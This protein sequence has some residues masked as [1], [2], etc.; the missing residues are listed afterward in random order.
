[1]TGRNSQVGIAVFVFIFVAPFFACL[2]G[3]SED[4][5]RLYRKYRPVA[6]GKGWL[7]NYK[8]GHEILLELSRL[9]PEQQ[10]KVDIAKYRG[11]RIAVVGGSAPPGATNDLVTDG[12]FYL[13]VVNPKG[14]DLRPPSP[15]TILI[16][17]TIL[18]VLPMNKIIVIKVSNKDWEV[19]MT[20]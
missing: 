13:R 3:D 11:E 5:E 12:G 16:R 7:D 8:R 15:G 2:A 19:L 10:K 20:S 6:E 9:S 4:I 17:G 1:M 14:K 18:Q